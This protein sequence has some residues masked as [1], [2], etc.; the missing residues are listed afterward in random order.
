MGL[1]HVNLTVADVE[2]STA[3]YREH[4][5]FTE[6]VHDDEHLRM[7]ADG[8]GSLLALMPG[9]P[10]P[11]PGESFH[12]GF[13]LADAEEVRSARVRLQR[14]GVV[15]VWFFDDGPMALVRVSD[16]DGYHVEQF[17]SG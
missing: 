2:R 15:E 9:T 14:A 16:P 17:S 7:L 10:P 8:D 4:F 13:Q 12:F 11:E 5:G 6:V 3:F 1:N